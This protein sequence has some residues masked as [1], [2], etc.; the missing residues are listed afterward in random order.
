MVDSIPST[1]GAAAAQFLQVSGPYHSNHVDIPIDV[2]PTPSRRSMKVFENIRKKSL[3]E[4]SLVLDIIRGGSRD[5]VDEQFRHPER[6]S[7]STG[8]LNK[9]GKKKILSWGT[10]SPNYIHKQ[11]HI[12]KN[13]PEKT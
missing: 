11:L 1:S 7:A 8:N 12:G 4:W 5:S 2:S 9:K 3:S 6:V 13:R 10:M